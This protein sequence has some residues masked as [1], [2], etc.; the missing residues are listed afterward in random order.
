MVDI[1]R[2]H[3]S[4]LLRNCGIITRADYPY[5]GICRP[6]NTMKLKSHAV[7][8]SGYTTIRKN[9][10]M[11]QTTAASQHRVF[12]GYCTSMSNHGG[13]VVGYEEEGGIL[14]RILKNSWGKGWGE[15]GYMRMQRGTSEPRD[16]AKAVGLGI[17]K[18]KTV[19]TVKG[20]EREPPA[21]KL[22]RPGV[23]PKPNIEIVLEVESVYF[24]RS[25]DHSGSFH[26]KALVPRFLLLQI[27]QTPRVYLRQPSRLGLK[28]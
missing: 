19:K 7:S 6:C 4:S 5:V 17:L 3:L 23:D 27:L 26:S 13:V 14:Y 8:N 9:K 18:A 2:E 15:G 21:L 11:L 16:N 24:V 28:G 20:V 10:I 22:K 12:M 25:S 1:W